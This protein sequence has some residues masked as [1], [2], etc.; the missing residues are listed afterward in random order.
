MRAATLRYSPLIIIT[1][2]TG[3]SGGGNYGVAYLRDE[4]VFETIE[5]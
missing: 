4:P 5:K 3:S 2:C 1:D